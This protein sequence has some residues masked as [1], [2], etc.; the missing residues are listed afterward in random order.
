MTPLRGRHIRLALATALCLTCTGMPASPQ[1]ASTVSGTPDEIERFC[2]NIADSARDRRYVMQA[3]ELKTLQQDIESRMK[4][5]ED[6]RAEYESWMNRREKF[7]EQATENVVKIYAGMKAD[8][9]A[10]RL[11]Q[12]EASLAAAILLKLEPR[13]SGVI[14]NEM[15]S[16]AAATLTSIMVHAARRSDPT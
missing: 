13:K 16:K 7:I 15:D 3:E 2:S 14:L 6:K 11:A 12:L 9:A 8:A 10:E 1:A 5:L 4:L